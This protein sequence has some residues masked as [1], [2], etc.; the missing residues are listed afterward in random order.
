ML[1][2]ICTPRK[3]KK[4]QKEKKRKEKVCLLHLNYITHDFYFLILC[5]CHILFPGIFTA[6]IALFTDLNVLL[7]L[8][9][10]GTL[11]V[12]Y[13]VANAVIYR[14]YIIVGTT[15]PWPTLSFLCSFTFT[16]IMFTLIWQFAPP[17]K[18]KA[19]MLGASALI[20]VAMLQIFNC[21]V[22]QAR[23]PEFWGVP[24][25]P[26]IPSISIFLNIFLLGSLDG[27]SYVRFGFFSALAVLVYV[28][29][30][31]HASFDAE[32]EGSLSLKN[33]E[34]HMEPTQECKDNSVKV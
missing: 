11:F 34:I 9:S 10:I 33:G 8:V 23:K 6:L 31:V 24:L 30:S 20:A 26:W 25:M 2:N 1:K 17:G 4:K 32:G 18:P 19:V 7:N 14:R 21:M 28:F 27:P 22:P 16:S 29:Y 12:F 13:M 3:K 15:N 5:I